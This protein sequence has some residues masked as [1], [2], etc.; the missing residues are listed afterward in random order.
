MKTS[1]DYQP[2]T[3]NPLTRR[4]AMFLLV[5]YSKSQTETRP[6]YRQTYDAQFDALVTGL[7]AQGVPTRK[8]YPYSLRKAV[9]DAWKRHHEDGVQTLN[10][11]KLHEEFQHV[12][13]SPRRFVFQWEVT[14]MEEILTTANMLVACSVE[15]CENPAW[16][17]DELCGAHTQERDDKKRAGDEWLRRSVMEMV[18]EDRL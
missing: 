10:D 14:A 9:T 8:R 18:E 2:Q 16:E 13:P 6:T 4:A 3:I 12:L 1:D 7:H 5:T 15:D 11:Q 17:N